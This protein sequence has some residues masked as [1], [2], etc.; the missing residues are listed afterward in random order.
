[1]RRSLSGSDV[2]HSAALIFKS[3]ICGTVVASFIAQLVTD[4]AL[5]ECEIA[6]G[7]GDDAVLILLRRRV[8]TPVR[9]RAIELTT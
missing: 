9:N 7:V 2:S 6:D 5:V 8:V 3:G 1:M 4:D